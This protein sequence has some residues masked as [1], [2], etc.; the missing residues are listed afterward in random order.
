MA[1][2]GVCPS[3]DTG[4]AGRDSK[5]PKAAVTLLKPRHLHSVGVD[6]VCVCFYC[7]VSANDLQK[8]RRE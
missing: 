4:L 2:T 3:P 7:L 1:P 5:E 8:I 6:E